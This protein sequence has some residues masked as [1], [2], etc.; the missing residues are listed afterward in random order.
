MTTLLFMAPQ[1]KVI[2]FEVND[3]VVTYFDQNWPKG[4]QIYPMNKE[5]VKRLIASRN[6]Q[7]QAYGILI[8]D[9]NAGKNLEEYNNCKTNDDLCNMIRRDC[10]SKGLLEMK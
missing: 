8:A 3:R 4:M 9:A 10:S 2:R 6:G 1:K 5:L 7:M